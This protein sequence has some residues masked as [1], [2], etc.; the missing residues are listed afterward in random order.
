MSQDRL[1]LMSPPKFSFSGHETFPFRHSWLKKGVDAVLADPEIFNKDHAIVVLGVGK[2]MVRSIRHWCLATGVLMEEPKSRGRRLQVTPLGHSIF[3]PQ[4]FDPYLEDPATLWLLHWNLLRQDQR[5]TTWRIVFNDY[6][7]TEFSRESLFQY[8][9]EMVRK[10]GMDI[11]SENSIRRDVDVFLRMYAGSFD[12]RNSALIEET[13][14]CPLSELGLIEVTQGGQVYVLQRAARDTLPDLIFLY[15]LY[16]YWSSLSS[17][18]QSL[19]FTSIAYDKGSPGVLFRL[20]ENSIAVRLEQ[21]ELLTSGALIYTETSGLRQVHKR[22]DLDPQE[23][24][25]QYYARTGEIHS[26]GVLA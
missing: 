8:I 22:V 9:L 17:P 21:L 2:N 23:I 1:L 11:Y 7:Y 13:L 19:A 18:R 26:L 4:G 5:C 25:R 3:G 15:C 14:E 24:L 10:A 6:P 12:F 20:D 16:N